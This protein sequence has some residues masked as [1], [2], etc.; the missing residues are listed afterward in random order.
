MSISRL[1]EDAEATTAPSLSM[2]SIDIGSE[3]PPEVAPMTRSAFLSEDS[4]ATCFTRPPLAATT[5]A[6]RT[7]F[8]S[9]RL[10]FQPCSARCRAR[11]RPTKPPPMM[12]TFFP[13]SCPALASS[14]RSILLTTAAAISLLSYS[15]LSA[16]AAMIR[17]PSRSLWSASSTPPVVCSTIRTYGR[18]LAKGESFS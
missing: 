16:R 7:A 1:R 3:V 8:F 13:L 15:L 12:V 11:A 9:A 18:H 17:G 14:R 5:S 4:S 6:A 10:T 2:E